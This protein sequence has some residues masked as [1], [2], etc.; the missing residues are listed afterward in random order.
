MARRWSSTFLDWFFL[1]RGVR[2]LHLTLS[3]AAESNASMP[4]WIKAEVAVVRRDDKRRGTRRP[5]RPRTEA[6][7]RCLSAK[8]PIR[9]AEGIDHVVLVVSNCD[10]KGV[11]SSEP[12]GV[13][14]FTLEV[15]IP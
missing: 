7:K 13:D 14:A 10:L 11:A 1:K 2:E 8:I 15:A 9:N 6:Q 4:A 12:P 5:L 3:P